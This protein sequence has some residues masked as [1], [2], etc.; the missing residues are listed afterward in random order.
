ME[1]VIINGNSNGFRPGRFWNEDI[2]W[3][4]KGMFHFFSVIS[5]TVQIR[6]RNIRSLCPERTRK[7]LK[8]RLYLVP[9]HLPLVPS[10]IPGGLLASVT[11]PRFFQPLCL[12]LTFNHVSLPKAS[13][14]FFFFFKPSSFFLDIF[15]FRFSHISMHLYIHSKLIEY[16]LCPRNNTK[17]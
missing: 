3:R 2:T 15:S 12:L 4:D 10:Y 1:I 5:S 16:L 9:S 11:I 14:S 7:F 17:C 8:T 6:A 13:S